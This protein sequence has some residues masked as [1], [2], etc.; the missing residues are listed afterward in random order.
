MAHEIDHCDT[1]DDAVLRRMIFTKKFTS[2]EKLLR[3]TRIIAFWVVEM[4]EA[5][6]SVNFVLRAGW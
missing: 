3:G 4:D 6:V 5:S 1:L 2:L